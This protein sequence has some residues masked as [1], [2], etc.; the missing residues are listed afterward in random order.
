M[1]NLCITFD[2]LDSSIYINAFP[3]F[4]KHGIKATFFTCGGLIDNK[5]VGKYKEFPAITISQLKELHSD[6]WEIASHT[7]TH[8][9]LTKLLPHE[10]NIEL[11]KNVEWLQRYGFS[12]NGFSYPWGVY[13]DSIINQVKKYHKY[14]RATMH[15][16]KFNDKKYRLQA[17]V[18]SAKIKLSY[19]MAWINGIK[20]TDKTVILIG[21]RI[22]DSFDGYS[23]PIKFLEAIIEYALIHEVQIKTMD[24][25]YGIDK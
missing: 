8:A 11:K 15:P 3:I 9:Y 1:A 21:H 14:A 2:D 17:N 20:N 7:Y 13:N 16:Q 19:A 4:K 10:V 12:T 22:C 23:W 25:I 18:L 5:F 6:G 24:E